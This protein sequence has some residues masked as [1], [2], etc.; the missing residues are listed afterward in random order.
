V[1]Q[2]AAL[3]QT[4]FNASVVVYVCMDKI[5]SEWSLYDIGAYSQTFMLAALEQGLSTCLQSLRAWI[6]RAISQKRSLFTTM[7]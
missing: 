5:L 4:M 7:K 1:E 3:N 6:Y 2:F